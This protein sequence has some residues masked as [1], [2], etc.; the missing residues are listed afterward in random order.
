MIR[1]DLINR[2]ILTYF[3][4]NM[5]SYEEF[6]L[7]TENEKY[8]VVN[9]KLEDGYDLSNIE[10][11]FVLNHNEL[12][13]PYLNNIILNSDELCDEYFYR[14][15]DDDMKIYWCEL[16]KEALIDEGDDEEWLKSKEYIWH[17]AK[18]REIKIDQILL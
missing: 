4:E 3:M 5:C 11:E 18:L 13:K 7:L 17:K 14:L 9:T 2:L 15:P 8:L 16:L 12:I 1:G 6:L 10:F